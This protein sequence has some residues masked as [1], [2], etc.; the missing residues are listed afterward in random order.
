MWS[1]DEDPP[2]VVSDFK[3]GYLEMPKGIFP[4]HV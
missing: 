3:E 1:Y 4:L 2:A